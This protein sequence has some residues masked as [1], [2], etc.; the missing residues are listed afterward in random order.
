EY[1][2]FEAGLGFA[3][4]LDKGEFIGREALVKAKAEGVKRKLACLTLAETVRVALGGEP[5]LDGGRLLGR[6]TSAGYGY[7]VEKSIAYGYLPVDRAA[8]GTRLEVE[9]F[10]ERCP[11]LVER[12]P[13]YDPKGERVR[14]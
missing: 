14:G 2:P 1:N 5:I 8:V 7:T 9:L 11:A 12:E 13:L 10:G 6:V 3:V 4:K